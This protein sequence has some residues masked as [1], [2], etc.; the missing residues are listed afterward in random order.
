M[1]TLLVFW[2]ASVCA[3][4]AQ[5]T[6]TNKVTVT[7]NAGTLSVPKFNPAT[8]HLLRVDITASIDGEFVTDATPTV[9]VQPFHLTMWQ[10]Y[11]AYIGSLI[12][13]GSTFYTE[14]D[15]PD[16]DTQSFVKHLAFSTAVSYRGNDINQ[17]K[18]TGTVDFDYSVS[19]GMTPNALLFDFG[20]ILNHATSTVS[21]TYTYN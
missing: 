1:K 3:F 8:G 6:V 10:E 2:I 17:W 4:A 18:G 16:A 11:E 19:L 7:G 21:I 14:T 5:H 12:S 20:I 13:E 9:F 15:W